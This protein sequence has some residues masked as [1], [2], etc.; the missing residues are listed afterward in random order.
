MFVI[1]HFLLFLLFHCYTSGRAA[2]WLLCPSW[3]PTPDIWGTLDRISIVFD[4]SGIFTMFGHIGWSDGQR[5]VHNNVVLA[6]GSPIDSSLLI[7]WHWVVHER[8][9]R[10]LCSGLGLCCHDVCRYPWYLCQ[11]SLC[12][13]AWACRGKV[14]DSSGPI[15][16]RKL[17][18]L[19][20]N[21][22]KKVQWNIE[23]IHSHYSE[24]RALVFGVG[25]V[26]VKF[27]KMHFE[28]FEKA[29]ACATAVV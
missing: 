19:E 25:N 22:L 29:L 16:C 1:G 8:L 26:V 2:G 27:P 5:A 4:V 6:G 12:L 28:E 23:Y 7:F 3:P 14:E 18:S 15:Q 21:M 11:I 10:R 24:Y 20:N 13:W 17:N 9:S